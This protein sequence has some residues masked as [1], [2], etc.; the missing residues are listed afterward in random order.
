MNIF[1]DKISGICYEIYSSILKKQVLSALIVFSSV[2]VFKD[3]LFIQGLYLIALITAIISALNM[4]TFNKKCIT[5]NGSNILIYF[6][7]K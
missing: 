2:F 3:I 4:L 5:V 7:A 1:L 6:K